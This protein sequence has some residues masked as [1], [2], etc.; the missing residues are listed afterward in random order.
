MET[1]FSLEFYLRC[2]I[3]LAAASTANRSGLYPYSRQEENT[4]HSSL[5]LDQAC[6]VL[7]STLGKDHAGANVHFS[8]SEIVVLQ[9]RAK[10]MARGASGGAGGDSSRINVDDLLELVMCRWAT[11]M[12]DR[13]VELRKIFRAGDVDLNNILS[14]DEFYEMSHSRE[15]KLSFS[16]DDDHILALFRKAAHL[17]DP[18]EAIDVDS[19]ITVLMH[20]PEIAQAL[21]N[22]PMKDI[23]EHS[24]QVAYSAAIA[25]VD[26]QPM[27][28]LAPGAPAKSMNG[29]ENDGGALVITKTDNSLAVTQ[30]SEVWDESYAD[31]LASIIDELEEVAVPIDDSAAAAPQTGGQK[32]AR[33]RTVTTADVKQLRLQLEKVSEAIEGAKTIM[34]TQSLAAAWTSL[35][36]MLARVHKA[37]AKAGIKIA[38]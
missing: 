4:G 19:F 8:E 16:M 3:S 26:S 38:W 18:E 2:V 5:P 17:S 21:A 24:T 29:S 31:S 23:D 7:A 34:T 6:E 37:K 28:W 27:I 36:R 30:L 1:R 9:S 11:K 25:K 13:E 20:D 32:K 22:S 10:D 35:R 12:R 14:F 33:S 15:I